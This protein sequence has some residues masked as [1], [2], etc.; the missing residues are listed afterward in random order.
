VKKHSGSQQYEGRIVVNYGAQC[1]LE[2]DQGTLVRCRSPRKLGQA[3][4]GDFVYWE[5][6]QGQSHGNLIELRPRR[7]E[8]LRHDQHSGSR[9]LAANLDVILIVLAAKPE[10]DLSLVDRYLVGAEVLGLEP[11]LV[12]NKTDLLEAK[13]HEQWKDR[14]AE[15]ST[16]GYGLIWASTKSGLGLAELQAKLEGR[17]GIIVG[18]SGVGKS[19]LVDALIPDISLRI[20][21]LSEAS[22]EG[23]HTTT[24]THLYPLPNRHGCVIDSPGVRDF[25]LWP[26]PAV[27]LARGFPE[28]CKV[29]GECRF[30]DCRHLKEPGCAV[31]QLVERGAIS[32][33][34]YSSYCN[35][36]E[37]AAQQSPGY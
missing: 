32:A 36:V 11:V 31:K 26:M 2:D 8:L 14:L 20:Q 5:K 1:L 29:F 10:A 18:Q 17:T 13:E 19:S 3:V 25:R 7:N 16:L 35:L 27:E 23:Q 6:T 12:F 24:S 21:A 28:L 37:W 4:C 15:F 34:R 22:G 30:Q 9:V 33:R